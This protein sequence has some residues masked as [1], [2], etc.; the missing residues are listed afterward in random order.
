MM[1][2]KV[3][4]D[5]T[6]VQSAIV[7]EIYRA[8]EKLGGGF[9]LLAL[10]SSWGDSINDDDILEY[11]RAYNNTGTYI[12]EVICCIEPKEGIALEP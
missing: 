11:F 7:S 3:Y 2:E 9:E 4:S 5:F 6:P 1:S 12:K 10:I 8:V